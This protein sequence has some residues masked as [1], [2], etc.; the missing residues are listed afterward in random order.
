MCETYLMDF[1][2]HPQSISRCNTFLHSL[3][4]TFLVLNYVELHGALHTQ[5]LTAVILESG[6]KKINLQIK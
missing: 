3:Q 6:E 1:T 4:H 2:V 5:V